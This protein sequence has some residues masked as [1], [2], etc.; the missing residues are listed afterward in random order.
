MPQIAN[1]DY[2]VIEPII[3]KTIRDDYPSLAI[4]RNHYDRGTIFDLVL[5]NAVNNRNDE[6]EF[7]P[8]IMRVVGIANASSEYY[9]DDITILFPFFY[10]D[11]TYFFNLPYKAD[12][13][14][15]LGKIQIGLQIRGNMSLGWDNDHNFMAQYS[16]NPYGY[17]TI[18]GKL[19][20]VT[21]DDEKFIGYTI[22]E[23]EPPQGSKFVDISEDEMNTLL[24]VMFFA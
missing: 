19:V 10:N 21:L 24:G 5:K 8:N 9:P 1:Q 13:L 6:E 7:F 14:S 22:T 18:G 16:G 11:V 4:L 20:K 2:N 12:K 3:A 15:V 17:V 23:L